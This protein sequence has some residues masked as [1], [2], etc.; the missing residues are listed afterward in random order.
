MSHYLITEPAAVYTALREHWIAHCL[1]RALKKAYPGRDWLVKVDA[2]GGI[3]SVHCPHI[4]MEYG[5]V[6]HLDKPAKFLEKKAIQYGGELLERFRLSRAKAQE[7]DIDD[8]PRT[9]LGFVKQ[10]KEGGY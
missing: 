9:R 5:F 4:S 1:G 6:I 2:E 3:A 8:L 10:V 7:G